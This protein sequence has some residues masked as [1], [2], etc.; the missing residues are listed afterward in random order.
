[1]AKVGF[2]A[3][4]SF[5]QMEFP[6]SVEHRHAQLRKCGIDSAPGR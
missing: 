6:D 1:M 3:P 4:A 5:E 2:V